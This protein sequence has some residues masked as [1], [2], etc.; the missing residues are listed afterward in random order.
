VNTELIELPAYELSKSLTEIEADLLSLPQARIDVI[1]KFIPGYYIREMRATKGTMIMGAHHNFE[2]MNVFVSGKGLFRLADGSVK[3]MEAPNAFVSEPGRKAVFVVEDLVWGN[4]WPTDITDIALLDL[5]LFKQEEVPQDV[6]FTKYMDEWV[7]HENDREDFV[8]AIEESGYTLEE[9]DKLTRNTDDQIPLPY[10]E[11]KF[12]F[13]ISSID[14]TGTIATADI[15]PGEIIG[16][17]RVGEMRTPLGRYMNHS[18]NPNAIGK[19]IDGNIYVVATRYIKGDGSILGR[20]D[21][22]TIDYRESMKL[23]RSIEE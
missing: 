18:I 9:V 19:Y 20:G 12:L 17:G 11:Y 15:E 3:E 5:Y 10:G 22:I 4:I 14:G 23:A 2:T 13:G 21:E 1:H 7:T 6:A 8:K 16:L